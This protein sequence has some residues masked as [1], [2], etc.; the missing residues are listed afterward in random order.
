MRRLVLIASVC[1]AFGCG[2]PK[3]KVLSATTA[4]DHAAATAAASHPRCVSGDQA[5]CN[6]EEQQISHV[7][8]VAED[9]SKQALQ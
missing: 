3:A 9:L 2:V 8:Q 7:R 4:I 1:L 6:T 5:F